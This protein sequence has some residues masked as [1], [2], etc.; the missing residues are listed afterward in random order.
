MRTLGINS[1]SKVWL[2]GPWPKSCNRPMKKSAKANKW[3]T[4]KTAKCKLNTMFYQQASQ[5]V[6]QNNRYQAPCPAKDSTYKS[7]SYVIHNALDM[8]FT[9]KVFNL[10]IASL[11]S[12]YTPS[13]C[14]NRECTAPGKTMY[15]KP[16]CTC[17]KTSH[18]GPQ[19]SKTILV[20]RAVYQIP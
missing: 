7:L 14:S 8:A 16:V 5:F 20:V 18:D 4:V 9:W 10:L 19:I 2:N 1:R 17:L 11:T 6:C 3:I 13:E 15:V 12:Q